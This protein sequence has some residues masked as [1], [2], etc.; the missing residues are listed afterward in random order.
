MRPGEDQIRSLRT[1]GRVLIWR[2]WPLAVFTL[3]A[4]LPISQI[5]GIR[6]GSTES[7]GVNYVVATCMS[8]LILSISF[9]V[10]TLTAFLLAERH[11]SGLSRQALLD[12][13]TLPAQTRAFATCVGMGSLLASWGSIGVLALTAWIDTRITPSADLTPVSGTWVLS[14]TL[15]GLPVMV[16]GSV[17]LG[18]G[19]T[20]YWRTRA[21]AVGAA[22]GLAA[23]PDL[24]VVVGV[25]PVIRKIAAVTPLGALE[26]IVGHPP[27]GA[28]IG[29]IPAAALFLL[30]LTAV[31]PI[32]RGKA[33]DPPQKRR[34]GTASPS[35][36]QRRRRQRRPFLAMS[37]CCVA[38]AVTFGAL[39]P[40]ALRDQVPWRMRP[41]WVADKANHRTSYD[42]AKYFIDAV[43][44]GDVATAGRWTEGAVD[45]ILGPFVK[46]IRSAQQISY[47]LS[48]LSENP[49]QVQ[50]SFDGALIIYVCEIRTQ[51]G[52][53]I[54][55]IR[56][57]GNCPD[58][59]IE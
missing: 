35:L 34:P 31:W 28:R 58:A 51:G 16:A 23:L 5:V 26:T 32:A 2:R 53:R 50:V 13:W 57:D 37:T 10:P 55:A 11:E 52:W 59:Q 36:P 6:A 20:R 41:T 30:T 48:E 4:L 7:L 44:D 29:T 49:G 9:L 14:Q 42:V 8:G 54:T 15:V 38:A 18:V 12:G 24:L 3:V 25:S 27:G 46:K 43:R 17:V 1:A 33:L 45:D 21:G 19:T 22:L 39:V 40:V 56:S 47:T